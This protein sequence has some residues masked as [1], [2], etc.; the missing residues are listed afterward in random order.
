MKK[1]ILTI[2]LSLFLIAPTQASIISNLKIH[3]ISSDFTTYCHNEY[4]R[5]CTYEGNIYIDKE[6]T[7]K[8]NLYQFVLFHEVAHNLYAPFKQELGESNE[9]GIC[10]MFAFWVITGIDLGDGLFQKMI[11]NGY[12][13]EK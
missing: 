2:A 13:E 5:G 6:W 1:L 4:A 9:E 3:N 11:L 8:E 7:D 12:A 10:D